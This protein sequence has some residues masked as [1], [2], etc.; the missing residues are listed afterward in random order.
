[1]DLRDIINVVASGLKNNNLAMTGM[2]VDDHDDP[3]CLKSES[4]ICPHC[5]AEIID[6]SCPCDSNEHE[7]ILMDAD[8]DAANMQTSAE[9]PGASD[10]ADNML[11]DLQV[12]ESYSDS[13]FEDPIQDGDY[14]QSLNDGD[15]VFR[16]SQYEEDARRCWIAD[17]QGRGWYIS[18]HKLS[19]CTDQELINRYFPESEQDQDYNE[20]TFEEIAADLSRNFKNKYTPI[21]YEST[22][23][24]TGKKCQNCAGKGW[25]LK[26]FGNP[27]YNRSG[28]RIIQIPCDHCNKNNI[29]NLKLINEVAN[30]NKIDMHPNA[31]VKKEPHTWLAR[32]SFNRTQCA[33]CHKPRLDKIHDVGIRAKKEV[34]EAWDKKMDTPNSKKGMFKG[35]T[36]ASLKDELERLKKNKNK[37]EALKTKE[38][39]LEFALRAKNKFGK[40][41]EST[42]D[43]TGKKCRKCKKGTYQETSQQDDMDGTLHCNKCGA[44][45]TRH[46]KESD[47]WGYDST[48]GEPEEITDDGCG[49]EANS[50]SSEELTNVY[51]KDA[52]RDIKRVWPSAYKATNGDIYSE[53]QKSPIGK[54]WIEILK[55]PSFRMALKD[56]ENKR[57]NRTNESAP[58]GKEKW[59]K[60]NK[61]NFEKEYGKK[62]GDKVLYAT[63]WKNKKKTNEATVTKSTDPRK[64]IF[65]VL[66]NMRFSDAQANRMINAASGM[67]PELKDSMELWH[68][69]EDMI[70]DTDNYKEH[71][72]NESKQEIREHNLR[73]GDKVRILGK[74]ASV[75]LKPTYGK[76]GQVGIITQH[77]TGRFFIVKFNDGMEKPFTLEQIKYVPELNEDY[78]ESAVMVS[79]PEQVYPD[80]TAINS[81]VDNIPNASEPEENVGSVSV[82]KTDSLNNGTKNTNVS[83]NADGKMAK[84]LIDI[85]KLS[86]LTNEDKHWSDSKYKNGEDKGVGGE[87]DEHPSYNMCPECEGE[88]CDYCGGSG[89]IMESAIIANNA[90]TQDEEDEHEFENEPDEQV[91]DA[92]TQLVTLSGGLNGPKK[93]INPFNKGDNAMTIALR[94]VEAAEKNYETNIYNKLL[95]E[96]SSFSADPSLTFSDDNLDVIVDK[97]NNFYHEGHEPLSVDEEQEA[98]NGIL[99][100]RLKFDFDEQ[101]LELGPCVPKNRAKCVA[102]FK[103]TVAENRQFHEQKL[104]AEA[105]K[106]KKMD[107]KLASHAV[108]NLKTKGLPKI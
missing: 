106:A 70:K 11:D 51:E 45:I 80:N 104:T 92:E 14:V 37:T 8:D 33:V 38:H 3:F 44:E 47:E 50:M 63:A 86:G 35:R 105:K 49:R 56:F 43:Q 64:T 39:E 21:I 83:I 41:S 102:D 27:K 13:D 1:M 52:E 66:R 34:K 75:S 98:S 46:L 108:T 59:V 55:S 9:D 81:S 7:E 12:N 62:K 40:I 6:G 73:P 19:K 87:Y 48:Y 74:L 100:G 68:S 78:E 99:D 58:P 17:A 69:I 91:L 85:L 36:K 32:T 93:Q 26:S 24:Q 107:T 65:N 31:K 94:K 42:V 20:M 79:Q 15:E 84:E 76:K 29:K 23:D 28:G 5:G 72:V 96:F 61:K 95:K 2:A 97:F 30:R 57:Y 53:G 16:V 67:H 77:Q 25:T 103:H 18:P 22:V 71:Y 4:H 60:K 90:S 10:N 89:E 82:T 54:S 88:G 101:R